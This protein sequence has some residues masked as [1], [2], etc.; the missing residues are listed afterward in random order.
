M[1][2]GNFEDMK[3]LV[4]CEH[5]GTV[6]KAFLKKGHQVTSCDLK[7]CKIDPKTHYQ[8]DVLNILNQD[9]DMMIA[10]PN[11]MYL[12][13]AAEWAYKDGPYHMKLKPDTLVGY[14]RRIARQQAIDFFMT[15]MNS[16][17][18]M[19]CIENP[20]GVMSSVYRKPDQI[21]QPYEFG[22]DAS[23]KTCLWLKN[24][25]PLK[26]NAEERC[27]GRTITLKDGRTVE[28]WSNQTDTGQNKLGPSE[29]RSEV[30]SRTYPG[31]A[32]AFVTNWG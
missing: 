27:Q 3:I 24:L 6:K 23:K 16:N 18:E 11:C 14:E 13:G 5:S 1:G 28:R 25:P 20:V 15:L 32:K 31:I 30:R 22:D 19:I 10:H 7:P 12:T 2:D 26:I 4:A 29:R 9:W 21:I 8:G 17:I